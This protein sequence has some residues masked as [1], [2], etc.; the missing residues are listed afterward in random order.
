MVTTRLQLLITRVETKN[1]IITILD[2]DSIVYA[3][4]VGCMTGCMA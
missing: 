4:V 3:K 2:T 1:N